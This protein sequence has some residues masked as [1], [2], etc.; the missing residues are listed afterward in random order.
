MQG[1]MVRL[2]L[3][4]SRRQ[5]ALPRWMRRTLF[6][7]TLAAVVA[8]YLATVAHLSRNGWVDAKLAELGEWRDR[9]IADAGFRVASVTAYGHRKTESAA[10]RA[11]LGVEPGAPLLELDLPALRARVEALPWV[12]VAS[13]ERALPDRLIVRVVEREAAALLQRNGRLAL[14]DGTGTTIPNTSLGPFSDLPVVTGPAV[15]AAVPGLLA[16][17]NQAPTL[18]PRVTGATYLGKRR[19]DVRLDDRVWVRL[20]EERAEAAWL[21]LAQM[22]MEHGVLNDNILAVDLRNPR[23]W[24]F[25]LPPGMRLRMAIE[26]AAGS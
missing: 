26:D 18:A 13:V 5:A 9:Q 24:A 22:E 7:L 4:P 8:G 17:L 21:R 19:W 11:A 2:R 23:Q 12:R 1:L 25:R 14:I 16:L 20:P 10:L 6:V 3:R 15:A